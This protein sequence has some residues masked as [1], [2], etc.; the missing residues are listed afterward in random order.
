MTSDA[1]GDPQ[2]EAVVISGQEEETVPPEGERPSGEKPEMPSTPPETFTKE[3]VEKLVSE[4]HSTLDKRIYELEKV[5]AKDTK[6][7][8]L[9]EQRAADAESALARAQKEKDDAEF[10]A[11]KDN[12]E[13]LTDYQ[14]RL[15]HRER[16]AELTKR[17]RELSRREAEQE[18]AVKELQVFKRTKLAT[19]IASKY[20]GVDPA[21]LLE[22]TDGSAEKMALLA[23]R[24]GTTPSQPVGETPKP[25]GFKPDSGLTSG[26]AKKLTDKQ[27]EDMTV[28]QYAEHPSV[29]ARYK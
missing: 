29:K 12:P 11:I 15:R 27:I 23:K 19:E 24:L 1:G 25:P 13:G 10:E 16:D 14:R 21:V 7:R 6:A 26:G 20:E 18:E 5:A 22:L 2:D 17:E 28:E 4:R 8:E 9:A 3:Q